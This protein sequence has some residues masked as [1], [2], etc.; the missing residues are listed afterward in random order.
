MRRREIKFFKTQNRTLHYSTC[1]SISYFKHR[2]CKDYRFY[3]FFDMKSAKCT[4]TQHA[5]KT[6][7]F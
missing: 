1:D 6:G 4:H 5:N 3:F 7:Y 2:K